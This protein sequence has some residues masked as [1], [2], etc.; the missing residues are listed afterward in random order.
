MYKCPNCKHEFDGEEE[1]GWVADSYGDPCEESI[2]CP[3][4]GASTQQKF[5]CEMCHVQDCK[6]EEE[7]SPCES[8]RYESFVKVDDREENQ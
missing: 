4:C 6:L 7:C 8:W 2:Y 1:F 3:E 5:T